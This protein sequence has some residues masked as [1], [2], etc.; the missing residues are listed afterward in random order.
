MN[1]KKLYLKTLFIVSLFLSFQ[2]R[3]EQIFV[4]PATGTGVSPSDLAAA[5]ELISSAVPG[6]G[7]NGV[8]EQA[9]Q[10]DFIL[11]PKLIRLGEA[12]LFSLQKIKNGQVIF[13][14]QLKAAKIDELDKVSQRLTRSVLKGENASENPRVGEITQEESHE[15]TQRRPTRNATYLG[16]GPGSLSNLSSSG[17]GYSLGLAYS[18]DLNQARIKLL[19]EADLVGGALMVSGG[20]G[21]AYFLTTTDIAPYISA[22]FGLGAS[23]SD[24]GILGGQVLGGFILGIGTGVELFRTSSVNLDLG[25]RVGFM[26]NSNNGN[27]MPAAS[28]LRLGLYF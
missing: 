11:R 14:S 24:S 16:F 18:W 22:D 27:G 10:A 8:I 26:M 25:F 4:E 12:Y 9:D 15:G 3:A 7:S 23:K 17:L 2:A 21:G 28:T 6:I 13:S 1:L 20:L 19:S 5:A